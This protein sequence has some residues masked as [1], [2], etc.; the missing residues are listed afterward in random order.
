MDCTSYFPEQATDVDRFL[1]DAADRAVPPLFQHLLVG[2]ATKGTKRTSIS[3]RDSAIATDIYGA[4]LVALRNL[5]PPME[6]M[7]R[8]IS[9]EVQ[10]I[11]TTSITSRRVN[12]AL[13][14]MD[15]IASQRRGISDPFLRLRDN[16]VWSG[17][18]R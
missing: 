8:K 15:E 7:E 18:R 4:F 12:N 14:Q 17:P 6:H 2:P 1:G 11:V 9:S 16:T 10:R 3:L 5:V 13:R